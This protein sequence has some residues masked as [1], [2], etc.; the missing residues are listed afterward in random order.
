M[1]AADRKRL[2][3]ISDT[4][5]RALRGSMTGNTKARV[6]AEITLTEGQWGV[7]MDV[8]GEAVADDVKGAG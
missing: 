6:T 2:E 1:K 3:S 8:L 7:L 5:H 4:V